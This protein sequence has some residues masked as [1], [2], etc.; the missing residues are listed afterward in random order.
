MEDDERKKKLQAGRERLAKFQKKKS[1][2]DKR[3]KKKKKKPTAPGEDSNKLPATEPAPPTD[4][5]NG[6]GGTGA[7]DDGGLKGRIS[8][9]ESI[10]AGDSSF[11]SSDFVSSS[12]ADLISP[13]P[14]FDSDQRSFATDDLCDDS[15]TSGLDAEVAR[16]ELQD[17]RQRIDHLEET[18][19]G[20]Q[21]ALDQLQRE[22]ET[23]KEQQ[24]Q[25]QNGAD[26]QGSDREQ[27][28]SG[29]K[30]ADYQAAIQQYNLK[31]G[32]FQQALQVRDDIIR[33]I[34]TNL[35]ERT[36]ERDAIQGQ[37]LGVQD[38]MNNLQSQLSEAGESLKSQNGSPKSLSE[39]LSRTQNEVVAMQETITEKD[40]MMQTLA[41]RYA[42]KTQE[43]A[44][45][46]EAQEDVRRRSAE[47]IMTLHQ[48]LKENDIDPDSGSGDDGLARLQAELDE[49]YG[50]QIVMIKEQLQD[51]Y[52]QEKDILEQKVQDLERHVTANADTNRLAEDLEKQISDLKKDLSDKE[53]KNKRNEEELVNLTEKLAQTE[54]D[55]EQQLENLKGDHAEE[56]EALSK[57]Q[58]HQLQS[59]LG[60]LEEQHQVK[61]QRLEGQHQVNVDD[62]V[63][64]NNAKLAELEKQLSESS[65]DNCALQD[66]HAIEVASLKAL[67]ENH[68]GDSN[69]I[70]N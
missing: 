50:N 67:L 6:K 29:Q 63:D 41:Q 35:Q 28:L 40:T 38:K 11:A 45:S 59:K 12:H 53:I 37:L 14:S 7:D 43:L 8:D 55:Y 54:Y 30:E 25:Q 23:L 32:E 62:L 60:E 47:Q 49:S 17:A 69:K 57:Q 3:P 66:A 15:D 52:Q 24:E 36:Q 21:T 70:S 22:N 18:L 26:G 5:T 46:L 2:N 19:L 9:D 31:I 1:S 27:A 65:R 10:D 56:L 61:L 13:V 33:Q 4:G 64:Q 51:R 58:E 42:Q 16:I 44:A 68:E 34:S 39:E 20:K 48:K